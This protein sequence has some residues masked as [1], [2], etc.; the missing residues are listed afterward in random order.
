LVAFLGF[1]EA[2]DGSALKLTTGGLVAYSGQLPPVGQPAT[3]G[4]G[5]AQ[6]VLHGVDGSAAGAT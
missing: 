2:C 3:V 1:H 4:D 5:L 6:I